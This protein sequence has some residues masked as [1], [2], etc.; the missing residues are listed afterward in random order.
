M[1]KT[2]KAAAGYDLTDEDAGRIGR[3]IEVMAR[4]GPVPVARIVEDATNEDSP[5]HPYFEWDDSRAAGLY[6]IDRARYLVRSVVVEV[7]RPRQEPLL[8]RAFASVVQVGGT[9]RGYLPQSVVLADRAL[10]AQVLDAMRAS[11]GHWVRE[12][13]KYE[14]LRGIGERLR[15]VIEEAAPS[16]EV[17]ARA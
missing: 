17:E 2:Y 6:R 13:A 12:C 7:Q 5:L 14:E 9:T 10:Y 3:R 4:F 16:G 1:V 11:L 8:V 15:S